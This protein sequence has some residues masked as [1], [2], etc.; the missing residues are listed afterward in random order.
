MNCLFLSKQFDQDQAI[1]NIGHQRKQQKR[2]ITVILLSQIDL[3]ELCDQVSFFV[4]FE[5]NFSALC[6]QILKA[7]FCYFYCC[8]SCDFLS[9]VAVLLHYCLN[10]ITAWIY[11]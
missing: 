4:C 3:S 9:T 11:L 6:L 2:F 1:K 7:F 5:L 8:F 10:I